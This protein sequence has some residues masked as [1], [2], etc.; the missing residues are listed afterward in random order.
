MANED[1]AESDRKGS[2]Y[3]LEN[4]HSNQFNA[5]VSTLVNHRLNDVMTL[6]GGASANFTNA[7]YYKSIRDLLGGWFWLDI[8]Q[9]S[10]RDFPDNPQILQND[11]N[12]PNRRVGKGDTFGYDYNIRAWQAS[13]WLQNMIS[14]PHWEIN[15]ALE[16]SYTQFQ[17]DGH[18]RNGRAPL[19]SYGKG[20][21]HR[22]DNAG[23]K[24]GATYKLDGRNFFQA[25]A[26]Y[27]S[28]APLF[29]YSYISPRIKDDVIDGL[30]SERVFLCPGTAALHVS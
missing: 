29:E 4:R 6:Q 15:Y 17:R 13:A 2:T 22:F 24:L 5:A 20:A 18:M 30:Q 9:F 21:T 19:N 16:M 23:I 25:H 14:L 28:R 10:E 12:N 1:V 11:L 26:S 27:E 3:I 7:H 8:D